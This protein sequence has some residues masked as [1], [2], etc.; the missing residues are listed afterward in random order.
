MTIPDKRSNSSI[1]NILNSIN[2]PHLERISLD[3]IEMLHSS[4][5]PGENLPNLKILE[6]HPPFTFPTEHLTRFLGN[7]RIVEDIWEFFKRLMAKG[8]DFRYGYFGKP[9]LIEFVC[10]SGRQDTDL[11]LK[12]MIQCEFRIQIHIGRLRFDSLLWLD[13]TGCYPQSRDN[14]L[15]MLSSLEIKHRVYL[16]IELY[17]HDSLSTVEFLPENVSSLSIMVKGPLSL[18]LVPDVVR[19]LNGLQYLYISGFPNGWSLQ[20]SCHKD[21]LRFPDHI[22][23]H[24]DAPEKLR[25]PSFYFSLSEG[26]TIMEEFKSYKLADVAPN[27]DLKDLETEAKWL[28]SLSPKLNKVGFSVTG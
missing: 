10:L 22:I 19:W 12:W 5:C 1:H 26:W 16:W 23:I 20:M 7:E 15:I 2:C 13:L 18:T 28:C 25:I 9:S 27:W 11:V 21:G 3:G 17:D 6:V 24:G 4:D 14:V 8:I